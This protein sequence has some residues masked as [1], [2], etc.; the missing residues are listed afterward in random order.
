MTDTSQEFDVSACER[1]PI[2]IPGAIQPHGVLLAV[3][4][5]LRVCRTGGDVQALLGYDG[6]PLG[7]QL[8]DIVPIRDLDLSSVTEECGFV[9][10]IRT[11][12][13]DV[14]LFAHRCAGELIVEFEPAPQERRTGANVLGALLPIVKAIG[15]A[16]DVGAAATAA[17]AGVRWI[18]G[19]DRV[20]I[21]RF[22]DDQSGQVIAEV[23]FR[24]GRTLPQPP[25]P[26]KRRS[27]AGACAVHPQS[28]PGH[29]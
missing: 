21:Y 12:T 11:P 27:P 22:L 29:P 20:M 28:G 4:Q 18:T 25:L 16:A 14:D 23:T 26:G 5:N 6:E 10:T 8:S 19:Y 17:A 24:R 7:Q 9:A 15:A 3:D 13:A 1:E 2:H